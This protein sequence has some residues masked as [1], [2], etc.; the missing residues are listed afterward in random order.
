MTTADAAPRADLDLTAEGLRE[1]I[2]AFLLAR[3]E[4]STDPRPWMPWARRTVAAYKPGTP[5]RECDGAVYTAL[6]N[7]DGILALLTPTI[8]A[9]RERPAPA[10]G[11]WPE[12]ARE[13]YA[14]GDFDVDMVRAALAALP[15]GRVSPSAISILQTAAAL[16]RETAPIDGVEEIG[17]MAALDLKSWALERL[18]RSTLEAIGEYRPNLP[19]RP[20]VSVLD[21]DEP[22]PAAEDRARREACVKRIGTFAGARALPAAVAAMPQSAPAR[23]V[24]EP[25]PPAM[26]AVEA[27]ETA[28][29][30]AQEEADKWRRFAKDAGP[31]NAENARAHMLRAESADSI[32]RRI[33]QLIQEAR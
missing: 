30:I 25:P 7:A 22:D 11:D 17:Y 6:A 14:S 18:P 31:F 5:G 20:P 15:P 10:A 4:D 33:D 12:E 16:M 27:L 29:R 9:E 3:D 24:T 21:M 19:V 28:K 2:A 23:A 26:T 32:V 1:K 8:A 13:A